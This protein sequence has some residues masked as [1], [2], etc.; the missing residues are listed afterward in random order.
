[1]HVVSGFGG[2]AAAVLGLQYMHGSA[3]MGG[4]LSVAV[5]LMQYI[6]HVFNILLWLG[7]THPPLLW[8]PYS[9]SWLCH[10]CCHG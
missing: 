2:T 4:V 10:G 5:L 7:L 8:L 6:R 3:F 9:V 1:V